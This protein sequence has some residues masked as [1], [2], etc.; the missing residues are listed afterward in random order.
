M[1]QCP[2]CHELFDDTTRFC[3]LHGVH[4][5]DT[6]T[7]VREILQ[8]TSYKGSRE[9]AGVVGTV[10]IGILVGVVL[11][12]L[13]YV[14]FLSP[15]LNS[16]Q[17]EKH[18]SNTQVASSKAN[19]MVSTTPPREA[20]SPLP[21]SSP[22]ESKTDSSPSPT[23]SATAS[24]ET[25]PAAMNEGPISTGPKRA[26]ENGQALIKMKDGSSVEADAAWEDSQGVWYRRGNM[27]SFVERGKVDKITGIPSERNR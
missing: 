5:V 11:S 13:G 6:S 4:L 17:A 20:P 1:K 9:I 27:V 8:P 19:Q 12:L 14:L 22:E 24:T 16:K 26:S 18:D 2:E 10:V 7:E 23:P 21:S 3:E 15:T 25:P